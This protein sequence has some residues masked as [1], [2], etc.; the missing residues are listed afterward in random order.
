MYN[1]TSR[2]SPSDCNNNPSPKHPDIYTE[3][4]D[5]SSTPKHPQRTYKD[6]V[7]W[8]NMQPVTNRQRNNTSRYSL[9]ANF[10]TMFSPDHGGKNGNVLSS[11]YHTSSNTQRP[12]SAYSDHRLVYDN[13]NGRL[14]GSDPEILNHQQSS[15]HQRP[16]S[17]VL[18]NHCLYGSSNGYPGS[19]PDVLHHQHS[20]NQTPSLV[21]DNH[22]LY[23]RSNGYRQSNN[24]HTPHSHV[25]Q[26]A[27]NQRP[28]SAYSDHNSSSIN[29]FENPNQHIREAVIPHKTNSSSPISQS[30]ENQNSISKQKE[31][32]ALEQKR[33]EDHYAVLQDQ[34]LADFQK[35]QHQLLEIYNKSLDSQTPP[36]RT[37][38]SILERSF[39]SSSD[40]TLVSST[41]VD[42]ENFTIVQTEEFPQSPFSINIMKKSP[43]LQNGE[44]RK[45]YSRS[46]QDPTGDKRIFSQNSCGN[47]PVRNSAR[48]QDSSPSNARFLQNSQKFIS[49][50][51]KFPK[52]F[53]NSQNSLNQNQR[54]KNS[55]MYSNSSSIDTRRSFNSEVSA[56]EY[57]EMPSF[58]EK[59]QKTEIVE[60]KSERNLKR[61]STKNDTK[62]GRNVMK[63]F[64]ANVITSPKRTQLNSFESQVR[65]HSKKT[66]I[67][68]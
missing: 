52:S 65:D 29:G 34:L 56:Q 30:D 36:D 12:V 40:G 9:P 15:N 18:D 38:Q 5:L 19:G 27:Q 47:V 53:G 16:S 68:T 67:D 58:V 22:H 63:N 54:S 35:R 41:T 42:K 46:V 2:K 23:G 32:L 43:S 14:Y 10:E 1:S 39:E 33:L 62:S 21:P 4:E 26:Q 20:G 49:P 25:L 61:D 6:P 60:N 59:P 37:M 28:L 13:H 57:Y 8:E 64:G 3:N 45:N 66:I 11:R 55:S 44:A 51:K 7:N 17:V 31:F 48:L 24:Y 50:E